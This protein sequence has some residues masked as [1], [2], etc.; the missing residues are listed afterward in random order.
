MPKV[1]INDFADDDYEEYQ[2]PQK[3]KRPVGA[4]PKMGKE[5]KKNRKETFRKQKQEKKKTRGELEKELEQ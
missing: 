4:K 1:W 2:K 5:Y 3:I